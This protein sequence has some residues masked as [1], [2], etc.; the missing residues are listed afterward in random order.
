MMKKKV[1]ILLHGFK[2]NNEDDFGRVH[3]FFDQYRNEYDIKNIIWYDNYNK[4]TLNRKHL[5]FVLS[6]VALD[7]N[8]SGYEDIVIVAYSTGNVVAM[9]L[10]DKLKNRDKVRFF[11]TVPPFEIEKFK[12]IE[13]LQDGM[14]YKKSLKRKLG[15]RRYYRIQRKL[16]QQQRTEKYP[17][18]ISSYVYH[19]II[20]PD[21]YRIKEIKDGYF[22]LALNDQVV[23]TSVAY[24]ELTKS[25]EN[26]ITVEDFRHDQLFKLNQEV[27]MNWFSKK[28]IP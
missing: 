1:M 8:V 14:K 20:K 18:Q 21:G 11:G 28:F 13:R 24:R 16:K 15:V 5:D 4:K 10:M 17:I 23:K 25:P 22:L 9:Y 6:Q 2:R 26:D 12:W 3:H 19:K 7:V 27:F